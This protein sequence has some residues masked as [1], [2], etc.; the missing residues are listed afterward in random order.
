M[1]KSRTMSSYLVRGDD[2]ALV[3]QEARELVAD[4]V[5]ERDHALVVEEVG[6]GP[7]DDIDVGAIVDA[8][9]T[10]PFL[11]DQRVLRGVAVKPTMKASK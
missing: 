9:L 7:G 8:C 2:P 1:S 10:P 3:A 5:G 6:G 11:I 4:V